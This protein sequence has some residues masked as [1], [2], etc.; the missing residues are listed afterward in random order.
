MP[1]LP[2]MVVIPVVTAL[3]T[4]LFLL[5]AGS[6][7]PAFAQGG[8]CA[9]DVQ[10]FCQDVSPGRGHIMQCL[11]QHRTE[12]SATCQ[13]QIQA[14]RTQAKEI[15]QACQSDAQ[16]FCQGVK[17]GRG[18]LVKCLREHESELSA[19]CKDELAQARSM[20]KAPQ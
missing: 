12:L 8:A 16:Q 20:R 10:K 19:V 13:E 14:T 6:H 17:P 11:Q 9:A 18:A 5:L 15:R 2:K 1:S 7:L 3:L 4:I